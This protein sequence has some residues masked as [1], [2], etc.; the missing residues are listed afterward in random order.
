MIE[1]R[2][3]SAAITTS[4]SVLLIVGA[5][6]AGTS[7]PAPTTGSAP[8]AT[9]AP[10][11]T[12]AASGDPAASGV[13][14]ASGDP[15][16]SGV[17]AASGA[18]AV[19]LSQ[20]WATAP[21]VNVAT[22]QTFRIADYAGRVIII[23]T[24]AIWCANCKAQQIDVE[25]ALG[26]LPADSVVYVVLDVDP[27]ENAQSLAAYREQNGFTGEYAIAGNEV[28]RSLAAEF[29]DQVLNPPSTPVI[30]VGRD[31]KVTLTA[32]GSKSPDEIVA[33]AEAN[34]A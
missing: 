12:P 16:A 19:E 31:G 8:A 1:L 20:A 4:I 30:V 29:G 10:A 25:T 28:A 23:E 15:A 13:P 34:G 32:F 27:N 17:P 21:L 6:S 9:E 24:M 26:R 7:A 3:T 2:R 5:C 18:P 22:G 11:H 33:L 14:A